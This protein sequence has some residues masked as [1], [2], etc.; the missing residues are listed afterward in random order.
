[1]SGDAIRQR[2]SLRIFF[3][4]PDDGGSRRPEFVPRVDAW[5]H[6]PT[7]RNRVLA[8]HGPVTELLARTSP[9]LAKTSFVCISK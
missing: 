2:D 9:K 7:A 6:E 5:L 3:T 1:M 4:P 8:D